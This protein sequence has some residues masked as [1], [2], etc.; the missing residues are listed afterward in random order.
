MR[1]T[2]A[3]VILAGVEGGLV[4][5]VE[6]ADSGLHLSKSHISIAT[7]GPVTLMRGCSKTTL[8]MSHCCMYPSVISN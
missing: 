3:Q 6:P 5:Q 4:T 1:V 8:S 2:E 7:T